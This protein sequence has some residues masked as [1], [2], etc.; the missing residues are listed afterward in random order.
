MKEQCIRN[1]PA[2]SI[3]CFGVSLDKAHLLRSYWPGYFVLYILPM[4]LRSWP[5][6][7]QSTGAYQLQLLQT[8]AF[9]G[10]AH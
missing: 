4:A 3:L 6:T 8:G 9:L 1:C 10:P 2:P 5:E 7:Q